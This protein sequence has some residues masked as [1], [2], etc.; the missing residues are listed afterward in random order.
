MTPCQQRQGKAPMP[1]S[2]GMTMK[3]GDTMAH[4][5]KD[6]AGRQRRRAGATLALAAASGGLMAA[7]MAGS[8]TARA[9]NPYTDIVNDVQNSITI[10]EADYSAAA[11][12][13]STAG[14]TNAGL[15]AE[16][17]GFD[18]TFLSPPDYL[19]LGLTAAG[20]GTDFSGH[21]NDFFD[22]TIIFPL[23]VAGEQTVAATY[24]SDAFG[25]VAA[26]V[27]ALSG[28]DYFDGVNHV[29]IAGYEDVL[30][31]QAETLA[32]LFSAGI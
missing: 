14:G 2:K 8:P 29:L 5:R 28:G 12:D 32:A 10:G 15:A 6:R 20:T 9:D 21:G 17:V 22:P 11:T 19:L 30:A 27:T 16:F 18:N 4:T 23:T 26:A 7:A 25:D 3:L 31:G 1:G 13:F 24:L